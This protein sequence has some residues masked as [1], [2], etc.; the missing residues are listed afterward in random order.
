[1]QKRRCEKRLQLLDQV[2][3]TKRWAIQEQILS[4]CD[5]APFIIYS[6]DFMV[7]RESRVAVSRMLF[8]PYLGIRA[9]SLIIMVVVFILGTPI[10]WGLLYRQR[11]PRPH[12]Y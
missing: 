6:N 10:V 8:S 7:I 2:R 3:E 5:F 1:M 11:L 4:F 9:K 12:E